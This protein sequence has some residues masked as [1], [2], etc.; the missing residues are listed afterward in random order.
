VQGSIAA[1][2]DL[3]GLQSLAAARAEHHPNGFN[4]AE[5]PAPSKT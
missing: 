3:E 1:V 4:G 5:E 2:I